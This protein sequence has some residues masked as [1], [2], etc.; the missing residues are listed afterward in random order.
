MKPII[1][2]LVWY[3]LNIIKSLGA[4]PHLLNVYRNALRDIHKYYLDNSLLL[5]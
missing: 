1:P 4:G 3:S 2:E 5:S